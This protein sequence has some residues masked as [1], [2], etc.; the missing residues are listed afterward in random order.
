MKLRGKRGEGGTVREAGRSARGRGTAR[1]GGKPAREVPGMG[2]SVEMLLQAVNKVR[3]VMAR[4]ILIRQISFR[5]NVQSL[6]SKFNG[7]I[8]GRFGGISVDFFK[9]KSTSG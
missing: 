8:V 4:L 3:G 6:S 1:G 5:L 9:M 7:L 2:Q